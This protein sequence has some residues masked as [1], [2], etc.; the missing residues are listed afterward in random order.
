MSLEPKFELGLLQRFLKT[1]NFL[2]P[3]RIAFSFCV[4][5]ADNVKPTV[6]AGVDD[7]HQVSKRSAVK[8]RAS[9]RVTAAAS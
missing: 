8:M 1:Q 3:F 7:V 9:L 6:F 5:L 4:K 2:D